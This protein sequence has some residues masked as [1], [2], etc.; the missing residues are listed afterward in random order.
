MIKELPTGAYFLVFGTALTGIFAIIM[1]E[2][3]NKKV[4]QMMMILV[5]TAIFTPLVKLIYPAV[6]PPVNMPFHRDTTPY[7]L[8][9]LNDP[10]MQQTKILPTS[11]RELILF[12]RKQK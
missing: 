1:L 11:S 5:F 8:E 2:S 4:R 12:M 7:T 9:L 6:I 3:E 10:E